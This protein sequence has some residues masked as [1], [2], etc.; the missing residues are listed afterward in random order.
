MSE[1]NVTNKPLVPN[2]AQT[3]DF[4]PRNQPAPKVGAPVPTTAVPTVK[5]LVHGAGPVSV[6]GASSGALVEMSKQWVTRIF[7]G[8]RGAQIAAI[9]ALAEPPP[10]ADQGYAVTVLG[11]IAE[12]VAQL[13]L[14]GLARGVVSLLKA[15]AGNT[16]AEAAGAVLND[17][18]KRGAQA[19]GS[20]AENQSNGESS[21][22][23]EPVYATAKTMLDRYAAIQLFHLDL[24]ET[25]AMIRLILVQDAI[26]RT[27]HGDV[28]ALET[29]LGKYATNVK[30]LSDHTVN[31]ATGWMRYCTDISLKET[32]ASL[33]P[34]RP[35]SL[36]SPGGGFLEIVIGVPEMAYAVAGLKL[37]RAWVSG[38]GPG[39]AP[40]LRTKTPVTALP[41]YRRVYFKNPGSRLH[42]EWGFAIAPDGQIEINPRC[43]ILEAIGR[44]SPTTIDD[45]FFDAKIPDPRYAALGADLVRSWLATY[46]SEV[47]QESGPEQKLLL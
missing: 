8:L 31:V 1:L 14:G 38:S 19:A 37:Q 39:L 5:D 15:Q 27:N 17:L 7:N 2:S 45:R 33:Y 26:A 25:Q 28:L 42:E 32:P 13:A 24:T 43:K 23:P 9:K 46:S 20:H 4:A 10:P 47:I 41:V 12:S 18:A 29:A 11:V 22:S 16:A 35:R 36:A 6:D 21:T 44:A 3:T 40:M 30:Y 34:N